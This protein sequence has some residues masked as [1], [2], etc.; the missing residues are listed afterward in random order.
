M[1]SKIVSRASALVGTLPH[2][3]ERCELILTL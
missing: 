2:A 3:I 1:N